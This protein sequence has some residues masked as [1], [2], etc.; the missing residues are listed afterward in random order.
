MEEKRRYD[1]DPCVAQKQMLIN[2]KIV[3][4]VAVQIQKPAHIRYAYMQL[5]TAECT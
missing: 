4:A 1:S 2:N 3:G 5:S